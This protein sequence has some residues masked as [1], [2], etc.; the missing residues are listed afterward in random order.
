MEKSK[1]QN[2]KLIDSVLTQLPTINALK[3]PTSSA[4]VEQAM[5]AAGYAYAN[6]DIIL[7]DHSHCF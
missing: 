3:Q 1:I 4:W 5:P 6:L 2:L 7:L